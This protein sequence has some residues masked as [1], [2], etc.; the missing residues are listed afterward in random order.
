MCFAIINTFFFFA[1]SQATKTKK[2]ITVSVMLMDGRA[3]SLPVDSASTSKE[4][5]Q[6]LA[7]KIKLTDT[8][9]FSLYVTLYEKVHPCKT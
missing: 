7:N 3:V 9:G 4:I 2:P 5:C 1:L 8:F 6:L